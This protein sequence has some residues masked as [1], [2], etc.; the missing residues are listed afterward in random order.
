MD[1]NVSDYLYV[2]M[3]L[4]FVIGLIGMLA[5]LAKRLG[6]GF[7][8]PALKK[9]QRRLSMVEAMSLDA[10]RRLLLVKC[11]GV[12]H[13]ILL[14]AESELLVESGI[15]PPHTSQQRGNLALAAINKVAK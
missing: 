11:D 8:A 13:L 7:S 14:G 12:E 3:S 4:F 6:F 15:V 2:I 9:T 1:I 10:K 5:T